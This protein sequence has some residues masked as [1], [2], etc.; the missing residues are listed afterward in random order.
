MQRTPNNTPFNFAKPASAG[1]QRRGGS[2]VSVHSR[3][4]SEGALPLS[5]SARGAR[6][7]PINIAQP[8]PPI[9]VPWT[10]EKGNVDIARN[11]P[12]RAESGTAVSVINEETASQ[13]RASS[14]GIIGKLVACLSLHYSTSTLP[15]RVKTQYLQI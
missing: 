3:A 14:A 10:G 2:G 5:A 6:S 9:K 13:G 7:S 12:S 15:P 8:L 11:N 1:S 4:K